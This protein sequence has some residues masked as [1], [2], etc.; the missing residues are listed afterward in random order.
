M[1]GHRSHHAPQK[2]SSFSSFREEKPR[3]IDRNFSLGAIKLEKSHGKKEKHGDKDTIQEEDEEEEDRDQNAAAK[4]EEESN[5][6]EPEANL[7]TVS[8]YIDEFLGVLLCIGGGEPP[9]FSEST[10]EKFFSLVE[11]ELTKYE[12]SEAKCFSDNGEDPFLEAVKRLPKL[13][14]ALASFSSEPKY[15]QTM[16]RSGAVLHRSMCFLE[17]EFHSLLQDPRVKP[18]AGSFISKAK[19][20]TSFNRLHESDRS[21]PPSSSAE[22]NSGESPPPYPPETVE[23]LRAIADA[24]LSAGYDM[25]CCNVFAVARRNV[26]EAALPG[27]G[28][29]KI[30]IE[31]VYLDPGRQT[32]KYIKFGPE[33]LEN[34]ID[35]LFDGNPSSTASKKR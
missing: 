8:D 17:D 33:D 10:V 12:S 13:T 14:L 9:D 11:K 6:D 4:E 3:E 16:N 15:H 21:A 29:D 35:E 23:K 22:S 19:Q 31:D 26:F 2:S 18:D 32:E 34:L 1:E 30:S 24:M 7:T 25:E 27:F 28:Y 20:Q 5:A